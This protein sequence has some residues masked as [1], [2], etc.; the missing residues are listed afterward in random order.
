MKRRDP[1]YFFKK[2]NLLREREE[3]RNTE[4]ELKRQLE[5]FQIIRDRNLNTSRNKLFQVK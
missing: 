3:D 2:I 5:V 4:R 1:D